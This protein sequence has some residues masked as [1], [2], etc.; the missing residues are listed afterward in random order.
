[1]AGRQA[2]AKVEAKMAS[3]LSRIGRRSHR[4]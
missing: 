3:K 4:A 2:A 1:M